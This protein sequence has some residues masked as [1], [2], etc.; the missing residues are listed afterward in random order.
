M[1]QMPSI[2]E[3]GLGRLWL[4]TRSCLALFYFLLSLRTSQEA[5]GTLCLW[6][7]D[8]LQKVI[9]LSASMVS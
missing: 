8:K 2:A 7:E 5:P 1:S 4:L 3:T 6:S 9:C